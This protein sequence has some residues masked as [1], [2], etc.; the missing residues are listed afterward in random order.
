M[1]AITDALPHFL[2]TY[3]YWAVLIIVMIESAGIPCPGETML[4]IA[5]GYAGASNSPTHSLSIVLVIAAAAT[6][7]I[8]GDNLG[9]WAGRQGGYRLL[10]RYGKYILLNQRKLKLGQMLFARH[11]GKVVFFGRWLAVLRAWAAFLAGCNRMDARAF[12]A[13]NAAGGI[14]WATFFGMLAYI[15]GKNK[16][17]LERI[18]KNLGTA[19]VIIA[20]LII[21]YAIFWWLRNG[22]ALESRL[23]GAEEEDSAA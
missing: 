16:D 15:L 20:A 22:H 2:D 10:E 11:G 18:V 1:S 21:G 3:G 8:V 23:L 6:G 19:G 9:Y 13:Y 12:V 5:A 4:L 17:Q 7:A 14:A